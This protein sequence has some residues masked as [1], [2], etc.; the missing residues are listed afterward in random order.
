MKTLFILIIGALVG[1]GIVVLWPVILGIAYVVASTAISI[2]AILWS[3]LVP[4][5]LC[6]IAIYIA[7]LCYLGLKYSKASKASKSSK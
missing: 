5:V 3:I 2:F 7:W 1:G 6:A 4:V